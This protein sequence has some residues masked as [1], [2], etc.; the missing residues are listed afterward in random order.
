M[1]DQQKPTVLVI[2]DDEL[3]CQMYERKLNIN[4]YDVEIAL[5]GI[6]GLTKAKLVKPAIILLDIMMPLKDGMTTLEELKADET[7]KDIPVV[8]LTNLSGHEYI[9]KALEMGALGYLI[10][11]NSDPGEVVQKVRSVLAGTK[12]SLP[13]QGDAAEAPVATQTTPMPE[14]EVPMPPIPPVAS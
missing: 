14:P 1:D 12:Y 13:Q 5:N 3:L 7:T 4:G 10:K 6:Q 11:S 9:E 8:M 2:E